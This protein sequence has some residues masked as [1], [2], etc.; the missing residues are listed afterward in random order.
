MKSRAVA[1]LVA[2]AL[3]TALAAAPAFGAFPLTRAGGNTHDYTDLY[4]GNSV[5]NDLTG[6]GNEFKFAATPDSSNTLDN[7]RPT[8]LGGVRGA[9]LADADSSA[10]TAMKLTL[11]RPDVE[12]AVL[13]SGIKWND[14]GAMSDLR[15]K[16]H[17]N[18]GEL[19]TPQ[20]DLAT[21]ISNPGTNSCAS[22]T[23]AYDANGDGVF[24]IDDYACDSRVKAVLDSDPRRNGPAGV[25]VPEDLTLAFSDGTDADGNGFV[26]DIAGWDFVDDDNDPFDD[27]QY[28]H[29]TGEARDSSS[30]GNNGGQL[31]SCPNCMV[32]PLRVGES[33]IADVN[34][35]AAA[36]LYATDNGVSVVQEALGAI[37]N[38]SL[39]RSAVDYAYRHGVTVIA[40]AADEAAQHNNWPSSLPHVILVNSITTGAVPAPDQQYT[41]FNGC[42]NFNAKITLAIPST[43]CSSNATGLAAGH[44]RADLLGGAE[45]EGEGGADR[46]PG[47][48]AVPAHE[49]PAVRGDAERGAPADGQRDDR[50]IA[51]GRR[52]RLR[53]LA[54]R[55]GE[56]ALLLAG[57]AGGLHR[58]E[59]RPSGAGRRSTARSSR[60][61]PSSPTRPARGP[62][63]STATGA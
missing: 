58:S 37:N 6:D 11:G 18:K 61:P 13:D 52:H 42:T 34:R 14:A 55:L 48:L 44:G 31:G 12:I 24:N 32:L 53:R 7:A 60:P 36:V 23:A 26:D 4:L 40:S 29:G 3:A 9:H 46:L 49:R 2:A 30:E 50:R 45:R 39:S 35:F 59:R 17:I 54:G 10:N 28:G 41:A 56:R 20:H 62:T 19:P 5:P 63:S 43:S 8:E 51:A 47:H 15:L 38:S 16:V 21:A 27:V 1:L 33:F 22:Y 57:A 25:L